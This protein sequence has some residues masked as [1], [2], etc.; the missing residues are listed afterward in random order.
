MSTTCPTCAAADET[1]TVR[2][3]LLDSDRPLDPPTREL[4]TMPS[5]PRGTSGAAV[6]LFVLAGLM[7]LLG[8][9]TLGSGDKAA[10]VDDAAYQLGYHYGAFLF[11]A[12]LLG[13]GLAVHF[14][15][16]S[17]R[18][19]AADQWPRTYEQWQQ[20]HQVWRATWLCRRC[21]VVFLPAASLR[22]DSAASS[23]IP[24]EQFPQWSVAVARQDD[25]PGAPTTAA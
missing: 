14:A 22:P 13:I 10:G 19:D 11:A 15:H 24:A 20:L 18:S 1:V 6:A 2:L 3:A 7:G 21:R 5:E 8:L 23:A 17:R 25:R 4:L 9:T 12:V 16:R